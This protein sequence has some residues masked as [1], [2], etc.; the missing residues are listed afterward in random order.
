MTQFSPRLGGCITCSTSSPTDS[1]PASFRL[2]PPPCQ[3]RRQQL[4][5]PQS[6]YR[7]FHRRR[8]DLR[9]RHSLHLYATNSPATPVMRILHTFPVSLKVFLADLPVIVMHNCF[10]YWTVNAS[11]HIFQT[12]VIHPARSSFTPT[13]LSCTT[14]KSTL[15]SARLQLLHAPQTLHVLTL[16]P[17]LS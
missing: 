1:A 11:I 16:S 15:L 7:H 13:S 14:P 12:S 3:L 9:N 8:L 2:H 4:H 17:T 6:R 5:A 10:Q